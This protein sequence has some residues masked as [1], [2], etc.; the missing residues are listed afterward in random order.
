MEYWPGI[1]FFTSAT[2]IS[3]RCLGFLPP[4]RLR[5]TC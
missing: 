3:G 4:I 5:A 1:A 2:T